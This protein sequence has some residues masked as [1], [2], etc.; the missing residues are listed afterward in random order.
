TGRSRSRRRSTTSTA[1]GCPAP[2][3]RPAC[4]SEDLA[5]VTGASSDLGLELVRRLAGR[6]VRVLAHHHAGGERLRSL[7]G[8]I[9]PMQADLRDAAEVA[10]LIDVVAAVECPTQI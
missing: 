9:Q 7:A 2:R 6:G 1:C 5:L 8:P 3:S 10:R 4:M